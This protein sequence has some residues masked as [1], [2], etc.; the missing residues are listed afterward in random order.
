M[1]KTLVA[2]LLLVGLPSFAQ[3]LGGVCVPYQAINSKG[4]NADFLWRCEHIPDPVTIKGIYEK[5]FKV[6]AFVGLDWKVISP[7]LVIEQQVSEKR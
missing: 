7:S 6:V 3:T 5:G 2:M 4:V 1:K